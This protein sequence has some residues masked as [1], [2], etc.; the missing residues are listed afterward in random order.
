ME[1]LVLGPLEV[2]TDG[3]QVPLGAAKQRAVLAMLALHAN[4]TVSADERMEGLWGEHPPASGPKMVQQ[5]ISQL[6][7]LLSGG[8]GR[9]PAILTRGRGYELRVSPDDVD[10]SRFV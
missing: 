1:L 8:G 7:K 10:A 4:S 2:R 5:Y 3:R 9:A 6:R